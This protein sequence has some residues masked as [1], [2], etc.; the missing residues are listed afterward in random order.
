ML[1]AY[2]L[3]NKRIVLSSAFILSFL[4]SLVQAEGGADNGVT[5]M[6]SDFDSDYEVEQE[7]FVDEREFDYE[8]VVG[9]ETRHN[10]VP[11]RKYPGVY[12]IDLNGVLY[13]LDA[14][15]GDI[16]WAQKVSD[17]VMKVKDT[18]D[19]PRGFHTY[20][21]STSVQRIYLFPF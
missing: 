15:N 9:E 7:I 6:D 10:I 4:L 16:L 20:G 8:E 13:A 18:K 3:R 1:Y 11:F 12:V 17:K 5:V 2:V 19:V 21:N 14:D